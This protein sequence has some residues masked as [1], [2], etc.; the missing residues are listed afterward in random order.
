MLF[1][2]I[3]D[4]VA[5]RRSRQFE[6]VV[7]RRDD[8]GSDLA[9]NQP[10]GIRSDSADEPLSQPA[11]ALA[12]YEL[13]LEDEPVRAACGAGRAGPGPAAA[14]RVL[15]L[16]PALDRGRAAGAGRRALPARVSRSIASACDLSAAWP[17]GAAATLAVLN[18]LY[19]LFLPRGGAVA[20]R[21]G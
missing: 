21:P 17:L 9:A 18:I 7:E 8:M 10:P 13:P 16:P 20:T 3:Q 1:G 2:Q 4:C 5:Q 19:T 12:V 11:P 14:E 6:A 15:V